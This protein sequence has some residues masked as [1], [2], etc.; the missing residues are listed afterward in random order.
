MIVCTL[1][2]S[3]GSLL[4]KIGMIRFSGSIEGVIAAWPVLLGLVFYFVGF[5]MLTFGLKYGELS[6][7][8]PFVSL[9]FV[10]VAILSYFFLGE[11]ITLTEMLGVGAIV[12]GVVVIGLSSRKTKKLRLR[13]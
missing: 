10:W 11:M 4:F 12:A 2:T 8:F 5:V 7:L 1:F 9:S 6:V 13:T 3:V